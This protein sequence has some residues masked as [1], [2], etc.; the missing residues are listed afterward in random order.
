MAQRRLAAAA[1]VTAGAEEVSRVAAEAMVMAEAEEVRRSEE[2]AMATAA[3]TGARHNR[4][5]RQKCSRRTTFLPH[6]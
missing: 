5:N 6:L 2:A 4:Y 1:R 3:S